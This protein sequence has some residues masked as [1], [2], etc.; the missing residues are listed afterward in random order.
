MDIF[1]VPIQAMLGQLLLGLVNGSFYAMLSLGLAVIFGLLNIINFTHGAMYMMGAYVAWMALEYFGI[2]FWWNYPI[3]DFLFR[4]IVFFSVARR[5]SWLT[6]STI[7]SETTCSANSRRV[8]FENPLGGVPSRNA[9]I[10]ASWF[11]SRILLRTR[12]FG[13]PS[14][15]I[16]KPSVTKRSRKHDSSPATMRALRVWAM[17][18]I[19]SGGSTNAIWRGR[20]AGCNFFVRRTRSGR[21]MSDHGTASTAAAI[22]GCHHKRSSGTS[23]PTEDPMDHPLAVLVSG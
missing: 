3:L 21:I 23:S 7:S 14:S 20:R 16:S 8:Q 15:V 9:M 2:G 1:G 18:T 10:L 12:C 17:N 5:V 22:C 19:W 11:P 4:E 6:D 13:L